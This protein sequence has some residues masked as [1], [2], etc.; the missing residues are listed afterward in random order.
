[1]V[2]VFVTSGTFD[3]NLGDLAGADADCTD[4]A[5]NA[6]SS[7]PGSWTAWLSSNGPNAAIDRIRDGEYQLLDGTVVANDKAD[8]TD[9][10]LGAAIG[11][12][13]NLATVSTDVDVWT[14]TNAAGI[15][16]GVGS[17]LDWST[18]VN[19]E[20]GQVGR[21]NLTDAGWTDV[22]GGPCDFLNR[23]YCFADATSN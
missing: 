19:A 1:V 21:A 15:N 20:L 3:G 8:L 16:P 7:L 12:D 5:S 9:G 6:T 11:L 14:A 2:Q 4:A 22:G 18:N 13:E 17:C 23:L 10:S